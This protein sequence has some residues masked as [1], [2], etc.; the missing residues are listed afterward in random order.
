M[1]KAISFE[2]TAIAQY[3]YQEIS[4]DTGRAKKRG[5]YSTKGMKCDYPS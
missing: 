3:I 4:S 5:K 2:A 1:Q